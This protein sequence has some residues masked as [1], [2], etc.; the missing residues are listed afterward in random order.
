MIGLAW[1][2]CICMRWG[3][4]ETVCTNQGATKARWRRDLPCPIGR[5]ADASHPRVRVRVWMSLPP[6]G[7]TIAAACA[8]LAQHDAV[9]RLVGRDG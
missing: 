4:S 3:C 5:R 7:A 6:A 2:A 9:P 8:A 1:N